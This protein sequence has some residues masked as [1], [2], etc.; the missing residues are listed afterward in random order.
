MQRYHK[1]KRLSH[2]WEI[3][4]KVNPAGSPF[5]Q[6]SPKYAVKVE[7]VIGDEAQATVII[8]DGVNCYFDATPQ[9][10]YSFIRKLTLEHNY[11]IKWI[12]TEMGTFK[13]HL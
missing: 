13:I 2:V 10:Y 9:D 3:N 6:G 1:Y 8:S 11:I 4:G 12:H 7:R 5:I